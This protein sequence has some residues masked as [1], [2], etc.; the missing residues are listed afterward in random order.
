MTNSVDTYDIQTNRNIGILLSLN[1]IYSK[2]TIFL[3]FQ[4][5]S[6]SKGKIASRSQGYAYVRCIAEECN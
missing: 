4:Q 2:Y 3:R 6:N 1:C 5:I